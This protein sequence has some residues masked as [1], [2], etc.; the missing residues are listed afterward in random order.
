MDYFNIFYSANTFQHLSPKQI[1]KYLN[2]IYEMLPVGGY[3][4]LMYVHDAQNTYHYGQC[5]KIIEE[6]EF[7][8]LI[9]SIGYDIVLVSK[10]FIGDI[11]PMSIL[12]QK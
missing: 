8:D 1:R 5:I 12:I 4:S 10:M 3:F 6:N 2:Q 7:F 11:K 9:K